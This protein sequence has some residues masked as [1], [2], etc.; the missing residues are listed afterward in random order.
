[1]D[2]LTQSHLTSLV[3]ISHDKLFS[4]WYNENYVGLVHVYNKYVQL[5]NNLNFIENSTTQIAST[6]TVGSDHF[7]NFITFLYTKS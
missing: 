7:N 2:P 5:E 6:K 4:D 3:T 1:M